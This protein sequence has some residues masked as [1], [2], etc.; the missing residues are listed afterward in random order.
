MGENACGKTTLAK[1]MNGLILPTSGDV[2]VENINTKQSHN[3]S[4]IAKIVSMTFQ[5]PDEQIIHSTPEDEI[6]F[7]LENICFTSEKMSERISQVLDFVGLKGHEKRC[8]D[9][10]SGGQKQKLMLAC[11]LA[12][13]PKVMILDEVTSMLDPIAKRKITD[14]LLKINQTQK[15]SIIMITHDANEAALAEKVLLMKNGEIKNTCINP[16]AQEIIS[17]LENL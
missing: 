1:H 5:N 11:A 10:L 14:I 16:D 2:F 7:N 4:K 3:C 17:I 9:S 13:K 12:T 8:T 6:A 15:T